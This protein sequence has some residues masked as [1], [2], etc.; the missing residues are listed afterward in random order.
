MDYADKAAAATEE[1]RKAV[2]Q[3]HEA[4]SDLRNT[5]REIINAHERFKKDF[6]REMTEAL[7]E[8]V[9]DNVAGMGKA[10]EEAQKK[11]VEKIYARFDGIMA[12]LMGEE[13]GKDENLDSLARK[14]RAAMNDSQ[15]G[16]PARPRPFGRTTL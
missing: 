15:R 1:L 5:L 14:V 11:A 7:Q 12:I 10:F 16:M 6:E 8:G 9:R 13:K 3:A 4:Q 2:R